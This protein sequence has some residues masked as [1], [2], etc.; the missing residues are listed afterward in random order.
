MQYVEL[1]LILF[2]YIPEMLN[3]V[4][5][6]RETTTKMKRHCPSASMS[7]LKTVCTYSCSY[8]LTHSLN[9]NSYQMLI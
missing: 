7:L 3:H 6:K 9:S 5:M 8:F 2:L 4:D 1:L